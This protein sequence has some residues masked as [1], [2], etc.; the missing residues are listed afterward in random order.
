MHQKVVT[1]AYTCLQHTLRLERFTGSII[2]DPE[3]TA[4]QLRMH[5]GALQEDRLIVLWQHKHDALNLARAC[6]SMA[7]PGVGFSVQEGATSWTLTFIKEDN[8]WRLKTFS[9]DKA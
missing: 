9:N 5:L 1:I 7:A 2:L 4:S 3:L 8:G 6:T